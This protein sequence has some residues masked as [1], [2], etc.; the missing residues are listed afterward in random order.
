VTFTFTPQAIFKFTRIYPEQNARCSNPF[1]YHRVSVAQIPSA[2]HNKSV[3]V[4]PV[5]PFIYLRKQIQD[6]LQQGG[7]RQHTLDA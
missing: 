3:K 2:T 4:H 7:R 6:S 1:F 5:I